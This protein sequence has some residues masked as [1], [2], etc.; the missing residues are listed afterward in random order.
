TPVERFDADD[1]WTA[2]ASDSTGAFDVA[3]QGRAVASVRWGLLGSHNRSNALAAIAAAR[4]AGVP[5]EVA[6]EALSRF[7]NVK[8]RMEVRGVVRGITVYDDFAHHPTA[9]DA[10]LAGLRAAVNGA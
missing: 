5:P 6:A 10:T 1:G 2:G 4:H 7:Q 8:R 3:W 9:I